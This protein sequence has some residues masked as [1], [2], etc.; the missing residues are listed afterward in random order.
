MCQ[1]LGLFA[2]DDC[3]KNS[4]KK[5]FCNQHTFAWLYGSETLQRSKYRKANTCSNEL[6]PFL[7]LYWIGECAGGLKHILFACGDD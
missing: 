6:L 3:M 5:D 2:P 4:K 7:A 1:M